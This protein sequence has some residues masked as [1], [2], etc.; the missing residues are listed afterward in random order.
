M[1]VHAVYFVSLL[2]QACLKLVIFLLLLSVEITGPTNCNFKK[3]IRVE[4]LGRN[5][6]II[7][8]CCP[9]EESF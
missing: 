1:N 8:V 3:G 7:A 2:T 9:F 6:K 4:R 5:I